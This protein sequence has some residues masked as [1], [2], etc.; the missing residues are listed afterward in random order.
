MIAIVRGPGLHE[1]M[2][3]CELGPF[4]SRGKDDNRKQLPHR[5][6]MRL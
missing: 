4:L 3:H 5:Q 6:K 1:Q 2:V